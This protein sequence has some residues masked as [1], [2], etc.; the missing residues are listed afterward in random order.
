MPNLNDRA[1]QLARE[2]A[3][4]GL[5]KG[6]VVGLSVQRS[7]EMIVGLLGILKAGGVFLPLDPSYPVERL[8]FM[9]EDSRAEVLLMESGLF[10]LPE[11]DGEV[12]HLD[13]KWK[14]I[15]QN[16][17]GNLEIDITGDDPAYLIYTSGTTGTP[18]GVQVRHRNLVNHAVEMGLRY[19]IE[20]GER[21]LGYISMSFDA[22]LEEIFPVL[23][24]GGTIVIAEDPASLVGTSLLEAIERER[25]NY[26]HLPVS[27]WH[28]TVIEME[29][30]DLRVPEC[31]KLVL[32]GGEQV[33]LY[34]LKVW[35]GRVDKPV[36]FLNAYGPT[37]TTITASL[38]EINCH[39]D[40]EL[41]VEKVP[42]GKPISNV[43][44]Y[45]LDG[46]QQPV[47]KGVTGELYIGG[48]GVSVGYLNQPDLNNSGFLP[49]PY[50]DA[51][52]AQMYRTGDLVR[53]LG[54]GNIIFLGRVDEQV[55]LRGYRI[56][57]GEIEI[58]TTIS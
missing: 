26:L 54:D 14:E 19:G 17:T 7:S 38:Y 3:S 31:L 25:I 23:L 21:M 28:Q 24:N 27:V 41:P 8:A 22:A 34:R 52:N 58:G 12:I 35:S 10:E 39:P 6:Q 20:A 11:Y 36:K 13:Q 29:R 50:S 47:P 30:S 42:I 43:R 53:Y 55:K 40:A 4:V 57:L 51:E 5:E 15:A 49:D 33:D 1:N 9:L 44:M 45:V 16:E 37:E 46:L 2:L 48:A 18:K 32:V 56:E